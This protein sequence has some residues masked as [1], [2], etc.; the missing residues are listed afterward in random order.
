MLDSTLAA[1]PVKSLSM[2]VLL[3]LTNRLHLAYLGCYGNQWL[4]TPAIDRMAA[5]GIVFDNHFVDRSSTM[6]AFP[7]AIFRKRGINQAILATDQKPDEAWIERCIRELAGSENCL[8]RVEPV[9]QAFSAADEDLFEPEDSEFDFATEEWA[10]AS[11]VA[12]FDSWLGRLWDGL[13]RSEMLNEIVFCFTATWGQ[14]LYNSTRELSEETIHLPL[15]FRMPG[16]AQAGRRIP[17]LTQTIDLQATFLELFDLPAT[18]GQGRSL[19]PLIRGQ[20]DSV[21][22]YAVAECAP[23]LAIRSKE[24]ALYCN[25]SAG[26]TNSPRLYAKPG[27]RWEVHNVAGQHIELVDELER[28]LKAM[29]ETP[30]L[31]DST[32]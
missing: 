32:R 9:L 4:S 11:V 20:C 23:E 18:D 13:N 22:S 12:H 7:S 21:R 5:E 3:L 24:W 15:I 26:S 27:D 2:K 28:T 8:L 31:P 30:G 6:S 25:D 19:L 16:G 1:C 17:A 10:H 14:A 29:V